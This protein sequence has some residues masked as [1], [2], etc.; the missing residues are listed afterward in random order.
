M[1]AGPN[2]NAEP[3]HQARPLEPLCV[4]PQTPIRDVLRLL[5]ECGRGALLVCRDGA[6]VGI[7]TERDALRVL[8]DAADL[9]L[10]V[11]SKMTPH[12]VTLSEND[13]VA[14]A[15]V[16]M[17][18]NGYR[19]LPVV[20]SQRKPIGVVDVDGIVHLLVEHFP[21]AVYNLPPVANPATRER[22]GP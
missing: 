15:V 17:A 6:L 11:E 7:F 10:P 2:L 22:E 9:D 8:A 18:H 5:K 19:R 20:D 13:S 16:Q 14:T 3:I 1:D 4:Q 21:K 12:P